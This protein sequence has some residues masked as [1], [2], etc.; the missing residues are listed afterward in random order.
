MQKPLTQ[1]SP[2]PLLHYIQPLVAQALEAAGYR[3]LKVHV[4]CN[5]AVFYGYWTNLVYVY[6]QVEHNGVWYDLDGWGEADKVVGKPKWRNA[7][8]DIR[9]HSDPYEPTR[10][11]L[12]I[13]HLKVRDQSVSR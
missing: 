7:R 5:A 1:P 10:Y 11:R 8:I 6:G 2:Q 9:L 13:A 12:D 3:V 4:G